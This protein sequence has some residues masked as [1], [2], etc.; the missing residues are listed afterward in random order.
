MADVGADVIGIDASKDML[1]VAK[2]NYPEL[3]MLYLMIQLD[4]L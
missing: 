3:M 4:L 2:S 1:E